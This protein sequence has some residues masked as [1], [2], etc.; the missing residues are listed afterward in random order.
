M[1]KVPLVEPDLHLSQHVAVVGSSAILHK[2]NSAKSI[3]RY[4]DVIRFNRAP[5]EGWE[6]VAGSKT[7]LRIVNGHVFANVPFKRWKEDDNFVKNLRDSN[8]LVAAQEFGLSKN[9]NYKSTDDSNKVYKIYFSAMLARMASQLK[10]SLG[11]KIPTVGMFGIMLCVLA[12][13]RPHVYGWSGTIMSHY[14]NDRDTKTS[15]YHKFQEEW[16][17]V[18]RLN[19]YGKIV[20]H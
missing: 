19:T 6:K 16:E 13:I 14:Y 5:T 12:D 10:L 9:G 2:Q 11:N 7:T 8:I 17:A 4:T 3:D 18:K 15:S 20:L 1:P